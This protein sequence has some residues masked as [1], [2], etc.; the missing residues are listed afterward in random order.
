MTARKPAPCAHPKPRRRHV[1]VGSYDSA[2]PAHWCSTCG[3]LAT[4]DAETGNKL[5]WQKPERIERKRGAR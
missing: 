1:M 4:Y 3:A 2:Q 5:Q